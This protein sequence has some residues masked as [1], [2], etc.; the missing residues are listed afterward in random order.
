MISEYTRQ[1]PVEAFLY[2]CSAISFICSLLLAGFRRA[3]TEA[4][5]Q[6][7][8]WVRFTVGILDKIAVNSSRLP[9]PN[10]Q[11]PVP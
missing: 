3:Y 5:E 10:S 2:V 11:K 9:T 1:N 8:R 6:L 7:P 4:E